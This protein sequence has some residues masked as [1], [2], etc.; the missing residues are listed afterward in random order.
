MSALPFVALLE[1]RLQDVLTRVVDASPALRHVRVLPI[2][3]H[4]RRV[5]LADPEVT[6]SL[7]TE[8]RTEILAIR[9]ALERVEAGTYGLCARCG[10]GISVARLNALPLL[11]TCVRCTAD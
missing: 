1:Q 11:L 8:T 5:L 3:W 9:A 10:R 6:A 4:E 2:D 7:D